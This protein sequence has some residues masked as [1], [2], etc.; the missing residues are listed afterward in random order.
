MCRPAAG[1]PFM[2]ILFFILLVFTISVT[3]QQEYTFS[4]EYN[5]KQL[6]F[7]LTKKIPVSKP[8]V[9]LALSGGGARGLAQ[10]GVLKALEEAG[11]DFDVIAGT[12]MGSIIGGL[13]SAGYSIDELDS[14]MKATDWNSLLS[15]DSRNKRTDLLVDQKIT[16][17]KAILSLRLE[18]FS[19]IIPTSF[20]NGQKLA[21]HLN[22]LTLQAPFHVKESFDAL[23]VNYRAVC[24]D[25]ITGNPVVIGSGSLSQAMRASS[26]V[27]F[28]LS[29]VRMDS[30]ILVDGGLV[31]NI[32]V[33]IARS[34]GSSYVIAVNTTSSLHKIEELN[35]PW[36]VA[37]QVVS[38]PMQLLNQAQLDD[39]NVV[40]TPDIRY[41]SAQDFRNL[42]SVINAG[43]LAALPF[44]EQ[45]MQSIDSL[46]DV[47]L[48]ENEFYIRNVR[49][50]NTSAGI[51]LDL[52]RKY[53]RMD[54][55]SSYEIQKDIYEL[56]NTGNYE[57][58]KVV[59]AE[60]K[61]ITSFRL[62]YT[63]A[64]LIKQINIEGISFISE[65]KAFRAV[66]G[67]IDQPFKGEIVLHFLAE[68]IGLYR[69]EGLSLAEITDVSFFKDNGVLSLKI[70]EGIISQVIVEGNVYTNPTIITREF[71]LNKGDYFSA[72]SVRRGLVN[73]QS[74]DLFDDIV[75]TVKREEDQNIIVLT[76]LERIS[77]IMRFGFRA[78]DENKLQL[79]L[80]LRDENVFGTGTEF[81]LIFFGGTRNRSYVLEHKSNRI[82]NTYFTYNI[83]GFYRFND[84]N[85][86]R[87]F[88][89]ADDEFTRERI[90]EYRQIFY[91][92]SL[93][94]GTQVERFGNLI[95][96]GGY[97]INELKNK[98]GL[99]ITPEK[100]KLVSLKIS[101]TIDT[102]DDYPYARNGIYFNGFYHTAQTILGGDIGFTNIGF[103]Y[104]IY[105]TPVASHT[106]TP[107]LT[108]GFGD[109]T[110]P[111]SQQ[112][113]L[114]GQS[115]FYGMRQDEFRGRQVFLSSLEYRYF[116]P[117][118]IFFDTYFKFRY[119]LGSI[120]EIQ[121]QIR[122]KDLRHGIGTALSFDT[123]VGPADFAVGRS[124]LLRKTGP[125]L[126]WGDVTF[127]FSI[128]FFY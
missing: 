2:K 26:S 94:V 81:G 27:S 99:P 74:T 111:L 53:S 14:I 119:D 126:V 122:F 84:V 9:A 88:E 92:G 37:D 17:D 125:A 87:N 67:L 25:L 101:S 115:S 10:I 82:F 69:A 5:I 13:Y 71:P 16:E 113:S 6:P 128:G 40:I 63:E 52:Q 58:I 85:A 46:Y 33:N 68:L 1:N 121:D 103:D 8:V 96:R 21:N 100:F 77:S 91:G 59:L 61:G 104:K 86:F 35:L 105:F 31:A 70:D 44:V 15:M 49:V 120:W 124:F 34:L 24:T 65:E 41:K 45:I 42:D 47:S 127:Y 106:F 55:V 78:D 64:P 72:A 79:S 80:D 107:R 97:E 29:P 30:L 54:S 76:V 123:P 23:K 114:G 57:N 51:E 36:T 56:F 38:I 109:K 95:F 75:L 7:G 73:L 112:Y 3:A 22:L 4:V 83:N 39:A 18:G 32:P 28:L 20:N 12:S 43:Y 117:F 48:K 90:G 110:L 93:S 60:D 118:I 98:E 66:D 62:L 102:Q 108:M 19:P 50:N 89:L 11:I 116:L